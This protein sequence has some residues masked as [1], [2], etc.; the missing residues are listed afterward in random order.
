MMA[1]D[2][3]QATPSGKT[4]T[5]IDA[6]QAAYVRA[7][8][9]VLTSVRDKGARWSSYSASHSTFEMVGGEPY[10]DDNV[11][12]SMP[13]C[14][15]VAGPV[16]W[17]AQ[18]IEVLWR[19][20]GQGANRDWEFE[21]RDEGVRFRAVGRMFR[22]RRGYDLWAQGG[23]W[24]GR[25]SGPAVPLSCEEAEGALAKL[26][27]HFYNGLMGYNDLTAEV[28]RVLDQLPVVTS[29]PGVG[30]DDRKE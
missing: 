12:L 25:G 19:C 29:R 23:L 28:F 5:Q 18:K 7:V 13:A 26:L 20:D 11:V 30:G 10:A 6:E 17:P 8:N 24:F 16:E 15:S 2:Q 3:N 14:D 22:W 1:F 9:A 27:R 4:Y 21:I